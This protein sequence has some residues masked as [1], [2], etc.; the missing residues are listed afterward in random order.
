MR[1]PGSHCVTGLSEDL[2]A[3]AAGDLTRT[4]VSR[5]P[6]VDD[7]SGDE[8]GDFG[9][10]YSEIRDHTINAVHGYYG[11]RASLGSII[12]EGV[13]HRGDPLG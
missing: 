1:E 4:I 12:G 2:N 8:I 6:A 7:P 3:A 5:T 11:T 10:A 13:G 9:R